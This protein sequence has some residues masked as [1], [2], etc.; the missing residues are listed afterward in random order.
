MPEQEIKAAI[1]DTAIIKLSM[2][3]TM[4]VIQEAKIS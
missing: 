4:L 2:L 3:N 1:K